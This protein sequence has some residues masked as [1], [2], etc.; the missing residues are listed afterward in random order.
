MRK[1]VGVLIILLGMGQMFAGGTSEEGSMKKD[2]TMMQEEAMEKDD[3]M[4]MSA[5]AMKMEY[6]TPEEA[7]MYAETGPTVLLFLDDSEESMAAKMMID[8]EFAKI[9]PQVTVITVPKSAR[10]VWQKYE[11]GSGG[12]FIRIDAMGM[13]AERWTGGGVETLVMHTDEEM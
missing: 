8:N 2:D 5:M 7:A 10:E 9:P 13:A 11:V 3:A 6:T 4:M 12:T 1:V